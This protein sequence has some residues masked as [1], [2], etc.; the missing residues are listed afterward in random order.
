MGPLMSRVLMPYVLPAF[1]LSHPLETGARRLVDAAVETELDSG[2]FY[3]SA[4]KTLTGP[5]VDQADIFA[6]FA[7]PQIQRH[8]FE[9][10]HRFLR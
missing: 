6:D 9:A 8:A 1:G 4:A 3:G 2:R 7:D 5:L 10:V